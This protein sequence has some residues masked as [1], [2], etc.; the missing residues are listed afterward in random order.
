M[1]I[2]ARAFEAGRAEETSDGGCN[3]RNSSKL[4]GDA[5]RVGTTV[6]GARPAG[7]SFAGATGRT[8]SEAATD[9]SCEGSAER[10]GID[11]AINLTELA[12]GFSAGAPWF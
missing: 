2:L 7:A 1:L 9:T 3:R 4:V 10:T 8:F 11:G 5:V 12:A 6:T